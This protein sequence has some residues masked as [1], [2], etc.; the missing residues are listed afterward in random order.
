MVPNGH[1]H[2]RNVLCN[3]LGSVSSSGCNSSDSCFFRLARHVTEPLHYSHE[4]PLSLR[5]CANPPPN[6]HDFDISSAVNKRKNK[7]KHGSRGGVR[8]RF[9]KCCF[10]P[11]L[12]AIL[13]LNLRSIQNKLDELST[14]TEAFYCVSLKLA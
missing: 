9:K 8:N 6:N 11:L 13:F 3:C 2:T 10:R 14:I 5:R 4:N 7:T 1:E 12:P